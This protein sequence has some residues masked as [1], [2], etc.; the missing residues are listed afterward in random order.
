[1]YCRVRPRH[2]VECRLS[3]IVGGEI[4]AK[5]RVF[6]VSVPGCWYPSRRSLSLGTY[7]QVRLHLP[8]HEKSITVPLA[9][10]TWTSNS[11]FGLEM[12]L[13]E[14]EHRARLFGFLGMPPGVQARPQSQINDLVIQTTG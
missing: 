3:S 12:L 11:S 6:D 1:M 5:G 2:M 4:V 9:A 14:A 7:V 10:V 13:M 8:N